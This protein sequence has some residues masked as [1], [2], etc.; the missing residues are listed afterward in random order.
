M[1]VIL[2][3][4]SYLTTFIWTIFLVY[5]QISRMFIIFKVSLV[6]FMRF[7]FFQLKF[8]FYQNCCIPKNVHICRETFNLFIQ[9]WSCREAG[10]LWQAR[11]RRIAGTRGYSRLHSHPR[12]TELAITRLH[13]VFVPQTLRTVSTN[14]RP[15]LRSRDHS[16][17]MRH[18]GQ[19][20]ACVS[21]CLSLP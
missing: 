10:I 2:G 7:L 11:R 8:A 3:M 17:P 19:S 18:S 4:P 14:Q 21:C 16:Q 6:G 9:P 13:V 15:V 1:F 5:I 12:H 20:A